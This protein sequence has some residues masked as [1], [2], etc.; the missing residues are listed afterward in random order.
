MQDSGTAVAIGGFSA[1]PGLWDNLRR[2]RR[3]RDLTNSV[4]NHWELRALS[5]PPATATGPLL[6]DREEG[7]WHWSHWTGG[8]RD[9]TLGGLSSQS[10]A[11]VSV[12]V[13]AVGWKPTALVRREGERRGRRRLGTAPP[14]RKGCRGGMEPALRDVLRCWKAAKGDN[15]VQE[16]E[17]VQGLL[18]RW[19]LELSR[20][21]FGASTEHG[22]AL[23]G[24]GL[25]Q[26]SHSPSSCP[27]LPTVQPPELPLL[28]FGISAHR[29]LTFYKCCQ[30]LT[31]L[32]NKSGF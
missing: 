6:P 15:H 1:A 12:V 18:N 13:A 25:A 29:S 23:P 22:A 26:V 24:A 32:F 19:I 11:Q 16:A 5:S 7:R 2:Q 8:L 31:L 30:S 14:P 27:S 17:R 9:V 21:R 3:F 28:H 4:R 20:T 10:W